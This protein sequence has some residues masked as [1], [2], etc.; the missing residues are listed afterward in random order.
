MKKI[1]LPVAAFCIA[2]L[3]AGCGGD[4]NSNKNGA[5]TTQPVQATTP[6]DTSRDALLGTIR[7]SERK[8]KELQS[9]NKD[10]YNA[11]IHAYDDYA[12]YYPNDTASVAYLF[13]EGG[14]CSGIGHYQLAL[15]Y[16]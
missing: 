12:K 10:A 9:F 15:E 8:L 11:A 4:N 6:K 16:L 1:S 13:E 2:T 7:A 3:L 14:L 5:T